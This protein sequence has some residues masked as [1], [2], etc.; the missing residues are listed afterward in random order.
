[1]LTGKDIDM[2]FDSPKCKNY[3]SKAANKFTIEYDKSVVYVRNEYEQVGV[4]RTVRFDQEQQGQIEVQGEAVKDFPWQYW[5]FQ[6]V[7]DG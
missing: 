3:T 2:K 7:Y 6:S 4:L 1:M 5:K